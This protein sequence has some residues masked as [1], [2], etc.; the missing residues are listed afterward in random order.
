LPPNWFDTATENTQGYRD[1]PDWQRRWFRWRALNPSKIE[2][3]TDD[4]TRFD[5]VYTWVNGS[6]PLFQTMRL[7]SQKSNPIFQKTLHEDAKK[8]DT[9]TKRRYR[10]MDELRYS[11]RSTID[12]ARRLFRH[13]HIVTAE[14]ATQKPQIPS[15]LIQKPNSP[16]RIVSHNT[17]F[18][19]LT[20]LPSYNSLAI[21]SQFVN[22]PELTDIVRIVSINTL[23]GLMR[24]ILR[25]E[26]YEEIHGMIYCPFLFQWFP[27]SFFF[28]FQLKGLWSCLF[29][30]P[31]GDPRLTTLFSFV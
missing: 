28:N 14:V 1:S 4:L 3:Q 31:R 15:W 16:I 2:R 7:E 5:I 23:P 24:I 8:I 30:F 26:R 12:Y 22:I 20:H 6:D 21:E 18:H 27:L 11:L 25:A 29:L 19:N 10:D 9:T 17:I 13:I